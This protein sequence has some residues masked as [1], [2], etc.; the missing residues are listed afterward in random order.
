MQL[1]EKPGNHVGLVRKS[2]FHVYVYLHRHLHIRIHTY[3]KIMCVH[4]CA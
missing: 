1:K 2:A 3:V 4:M